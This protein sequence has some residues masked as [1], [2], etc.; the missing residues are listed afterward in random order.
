MKRNRV[1]LTESQLHRVIKESVKK[2]LKNT[3]EHRT[4]NESVKMPD[5]KNI[6]PFKK[7]QELGFEPEYTC[8]NSLE[9]WGKTIKSDNIYSTLYALGIK[10]FT[11]WNR[12]GHVQI[13]VKNVE[14]P[15][16]HPDYM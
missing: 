7:A 4:L 6:V 14:P 8:G 12:N 1:R 2:V 5:M 3:I 15:Q 16:T 10:R 11:S 13:T 9:L